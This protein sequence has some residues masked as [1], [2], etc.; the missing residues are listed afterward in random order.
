MVRFRDRFRLVAPRSSTKTT[1][2]TISSTSNKQ[3]IKNRGLQNS[4]GEY[5]P[6]R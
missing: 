3:K 2:L 6:I 5:Y 4:R 1:A